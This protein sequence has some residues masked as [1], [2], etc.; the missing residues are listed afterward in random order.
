VDFAGISSDSA[1]FRL[2]VALGIGLLLG[3]ERE[4]TKGTGPTRRPAGVRTFALVALLGGI[5]MVVGSGA[6]VAVALAFVAVA[7]LIAYVLGDRSDPGLTTEVALLVT[8]LLGALAQDEP[9]LAAGLGA[10]VAILLASRGYLQRMVSQALTEQELHD[11]LLFA[12]AALVILPLAPDEALG[13]YG[14]LNP[15]TIWRLVVIVMA[16]SAAGYI[17]LRLLGP[18]VGLPLAGFAGGFVSSTATIGAMGSRARREPELVQG[19]VAAAVLSTVATVLQMLIVVGATDR[20]AL[21]EIGPAMTVAGICAAAYGLLFGLRSLRSDAP[22]DAAK[23]RAFEPKTAVVFA[24]T[25]TVIL[26]VSATLNDLFGEAGVTISAAFAGLADTHGAAIAVASLVATGDLAAE[27]AVLPI[28]AAFTTNSISKAVVA[29]LSGGRRF[30]FQIWP[31]LVLVLAG[32]WAGWLGW[33][34][35]GN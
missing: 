32:A 10:A 27:D 24:L 8:F 1:G 15:F 19:A 5:A 28:L 6:V 11:G 7:V 18:K 12:G 9:Q 22:V 29:Y 30:A 25:V 13:P 20:S 2:A 3:V 31:G 34:A 33:L 17:G 21:M 26:L 4:R 35:L 16:I 23:G 14:S